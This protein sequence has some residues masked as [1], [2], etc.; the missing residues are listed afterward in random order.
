MD[1]PILDF[2]R[3]LE[4]G[5]ANRSVIDACSRTLKAISNHAEGVYEGLLSEELAS[6]EVFARN[7]I[8]HTAYLTTALDVL[9][10]EGM[11]EQRRGKYFV[12]E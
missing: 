12:K 7:H 6:E 4:R 10:A 3:N 9:E 2:I 11:I 1:V 8:H 5:G